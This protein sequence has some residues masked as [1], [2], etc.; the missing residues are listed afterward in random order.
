MNIELHLD[1]VCACHHSRT[2]FHI[3]HIAL[4][5]QWFEHHDIMNWPKIPHTSHY[6]ASY[7]LSIVSVLEKN[8]C[9]AMWLDC[10]MMQCSGWVSGCLLQIAPGHWWVKCNSTVHIVHSLLMVYTRN[11]AHGLFILWFWFCVVQ[12]YSTHILFGV[13]VLHWINHHWINQL[14]EHQTQSP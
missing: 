4:Q 2:S 5:L 11:I 8:C 13:I 9:F 3:L 14:L 7:G 12:I 6:W 1:I 10:V